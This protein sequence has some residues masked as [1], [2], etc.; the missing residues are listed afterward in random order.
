MRDQ[1]LFALTVVLSVS[2]CGGAAPSKPL[3]TPGGSIEWMAT[4]GKSE[5]VDITVT[6]DGIVVAHPVME[7]RRHGE[8]QGPAADCS[9]VRTSPT[10][11]GFRCGDGEWKATL[12]HGVVEI[13]AIDDYNEIDSDFVVRGGGQT[14]IARTATS[15][16]QLVAPC[17]ANEIASDNMWAKDHE[18][19]D[20]R[21]PYDPGSCVGLH[22]GSVPALRATSQCC[23]DPARC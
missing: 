18:P 1:N 2:A 4:D 3:R 19:T 6:L 22:P 17:T 5:E 11:V 7:H 13:W 9:V 10:I 20:R 23:P 8:D 14:K 12:S 16:Y 15:A 21:S